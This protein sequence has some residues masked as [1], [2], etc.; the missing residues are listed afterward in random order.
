MRVSSEPAFVLHARDYGETSLL[1]ELFTPNYGRVSAIAKGA[2][3]AR[4][5]YGG[6]INMFQRFLIG[7]SGRTELVTLTNHETVSGPL[8]LSG[9]AIYCGFYLNELILKLLHRYDAHPELFDRYCQTLDELENSYD[10]SVL[11]IFEKYLLSEIGYALLLDHCVGEN[12]PIEA[13]QLYQ[14]IVDR[15]PVALG[16][17]EKAAG[18]IEISGKSLIAFQEESMNDELVK[19]EVKKLT[20]SVIN[21]HLSGKPLN[22]RKLFSTVSAKSK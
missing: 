1:V 5:R 22:S 7:W 20:R 17:N 6:T 18:G 21:Y 3:K 19:K 15:G 14:Y 9:K 4:S 16:P 13:Q 11:R 2:R 12:Q 10:E 8:A